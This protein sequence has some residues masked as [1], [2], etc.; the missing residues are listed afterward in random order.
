MVFSVSCSK[1]SISDILENPSQYQGKEVNISG[2]VTDKYWIDI[3][4]LK[5]GAYQIDDES[6]KIWVITEQEPPAKGEKASVK[7]TVSTAGKIGDR[8]FGTV[9]TETI[10]K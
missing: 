6:G 3:L 10:E 4:G 7:G 1:V 5:G 9:I 2:T 8:S